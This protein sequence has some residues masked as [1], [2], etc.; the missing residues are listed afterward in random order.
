M[1]KSVPELNL[2]L[3][4]RDENQYATYNWEC[5]LFKNYWGPIYSVPN[6]Q[7]SL[8]TY[9]FDAHVIDFARLPKF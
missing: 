5:F 1:Q 2:G 8:T 6:T 3:H 9:S 7:N 4:F